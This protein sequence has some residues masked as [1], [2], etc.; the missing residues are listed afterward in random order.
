VKINIKLKYKNE[1][2]DDLFY[3]KQKGSSKWLNVEKK[4]LRKK[5]VRKKEEDKLDLF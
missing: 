2:F 3:L 1:S 5:K 4:R